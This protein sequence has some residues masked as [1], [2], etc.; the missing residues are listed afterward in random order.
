MKHFLSPI[1]LVVLLF[2]ALAFGE[3]MGDLVERDGLH[4][5]KFTDV[6][7]S[8]TVTGKH[9]GKIRNGKKYGPWVRYLDNEQLFSKGPYK[10]G[11][12][13]GAWVN[14]WNNVQVHFKGTYK[15]GGIISD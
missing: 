3:T 15:D 13:V 9:Q 4:Y 6:P 14:Y 11:T 12:K 8:G 5:K 2:P 1:L 7:F 10:D